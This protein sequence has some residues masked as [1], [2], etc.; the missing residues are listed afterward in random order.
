MEIFMKKTV[1]K[2]FIEIYYTYVVLWLYE[3]K[4]FRHIDEV[5]A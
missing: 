2:K 1:L 5:A 3:S 4:D